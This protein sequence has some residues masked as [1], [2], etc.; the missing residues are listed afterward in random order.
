VKEMG[1]TSSDEPYSNSPDRNLSSYGRKRPPY[2]QISEKEVNRVVTRARDNPLEGG[3]PEKKRG[4]IGQL[5][6]F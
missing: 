3:E 6:H 2:Y 5:C 1:Q 4:F